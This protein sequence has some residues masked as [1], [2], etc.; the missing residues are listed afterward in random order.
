MDKKPDDPS[1]R[2]SVIAKNLM[3]KL[4]KG[5]IRIKRLVKK[6]NGQLSE[7]DTL[8]SESQPP[9]LGSVVDDSLVSQ[10]DYKF[11]RQKDA[12]SFQP[13]TQ[14]SELKFQSASP[15]DFQNTDLP[16]L[17]LQSFKKKKETEAAGEM[18]NIS[19]VET[20]T[21]M[22]EKDIRESLQRKIKIESITEHENEDLTVPSISKHSG[23]SRESQLFRLPAKVEE[24]VGQKEQVG[25]Q[26]RLKVQQEKRQALEKLEFFKSKLLS[27]I[28][29]R[30]QTFGDR[31]TRTFDGYLEGCQNDLDYLES[32]GREFKNLEHKGVGSKGKRLRFEEFEYFAQDSGERLK[33]EKSEIVCSPENEETISRKKE[34]DFLTEMMEKKLVYVPGFAK[35]ETANEFIEE[36]VVNL[37]SFCDNNLKFLEDVLYNKK[38]ISLGQIKQQYKI[39]EVQIEAKQQ[40][41]IENT[42]IHNIWKNSIER[43]R[44]RESRGEKDEKT[45]QELLKREEMLNSMKVFDEQVKE[46]Q[47]KIKKE[48]L[49]EMKQSKESDFK[50]KEEP[51]QKKESQESAD[52]S[53]ALTLEQQMIIEENREK[54]E[55][56]LKKQKEMRNSGRAKSTY[57]KMSV[58]S[59]KEE[60]L[61]DDQE[62]KEVLAQKNAEALNHLIKNKDQQPEALEDMLDDNQFKAE[63]SPPP[64]NP[65]PKP[66]QKIEETA[67]T[68]KVDIAKILRDQEKKEQEKTEK[69]RI[70]NLEFKRSNISIEKIVKGKKLNGVSQAG[71]KLF[72]FGDEFIF[73][74]SLQFQDPV[75][76]RLGGKELTFMRC[77]EHEVGPDH[78]LLGVIN[79][80]SASSEVLLIRLTQQFS[81]LKRTRVEESQ[82]SGI[83]NIF[84]LDGKKQF[85]C[86]TRFGL[87]QLWDFSEPMLQMVSQENLNGE[88]IETVIIT[89]R[90]TSLCLVSQNSQIIGVEIVLDP[91]TGRAKNVV[92]SRI[93]PL[94]NQANDIVKVS[95]DQVGYCD[96]EG[97][98]SLLTFP[99]EINGNRLGIKKTRVCEFPVDKLFVLESEQ[100]EELN[101][102]QDIR[103]LLMINY[104]GHV[105]VFDFKKR[106]KQKHFDPKL[107]QD[108]CLHSQNAILSKRS[109]SQFDVLL[110]S[111]STLKKLIIEKQ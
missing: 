91:E 15:M 2:E 5:K 106:K 35:T 38:L 109:E 17:K 52:R 28:E 87:V 61:A 49:D 83:I 24:Y 53:S 3:R 32:K 80:A 13:S 111:T 100:N 18:V 71:D 79:K 55:L 23:Y 26:L 103:R 85:I 11:T 77:I 42:E 96:E 54:H 97:M 57:E 110:L 89:A 16:P 64:Q 84:N 105:A 88:R 95:E 46:Y 67:P 27:T 86:I 104:E 93:L 33:S 72:F 20:F 58:Y 4:K 82:A 30:M 94:D 7:R 73:K 68:Q 9:T 59:M 47:E 60:F 76:Y 66:E 48:E 36:T 75:M 98:F 29:M 21:Q 19:K 81:L 34:L 56:F 39:R 107:V 101:F 74:C 14:F 10:V 99:M 12:Q 92:K 102:R 1:I 70:L 8:L 44:E 37:E 50:I 65:E 6:S 40:K 108:I 51:P 90:Q 63:E 31:L 22:I 41:Q 43:Q 78:Y 62:S 25:A 69:Q 45:E